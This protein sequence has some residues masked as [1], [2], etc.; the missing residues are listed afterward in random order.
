MLLAPAKE[1]IDHHSIKRLYIYT[2]S[3]HSNSIVLLDSPIRDDPP[4]PRQHSTN[5]RCIHRTGRI[6][7]ESL[8]RKQAFQLTYAVHR[9]PGWGSLCVQVIFFRFDS[10]HHMYNA[11]TH[12]QQREEKNAKNE[13]NRR[14]VLCRKR[15][16]TEFRFALRVIYVAGCSL[17]PL[18]AI[19][20]NA[21]ASSLATFAP[22]RDNGS[23]QSSPIN[24]TFPTHCYTNAS[25]HCPSPSSSCWLVF[26]QRCCCCCL[27][28]SP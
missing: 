16:Q 22:H 3:S 15:L 12:T 11:Q 4:S 21:S 18:V 6:P 8:G 27:S 17:M 20:G 24:K 5:S 1:F 23:C 7:V 9:F 2:S 26:I 10:R 19:P 13:R 28:N 25:F 14:A